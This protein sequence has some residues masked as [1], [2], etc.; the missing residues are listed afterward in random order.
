MVSDKAFDYACLFANK[1]KADLVLLHVV[2]EENIPRDQIEGSPFT[3]PSGHEK[4]VNQKLETLRNDAEQAHGIVARTRIESGQVDEVIARI[5]D[6]EKIDLIVMGTSGAQ[7]ISEIFQATNT[8]SVIEKSRCPV[9][10]IPEDTVYT[11]PEKWIFASGLDNEFEILANE[12]ASLSSS[13]NAKLEVLNVVKKKEERS[14][15]TYTHNFGH[16]NISFTQIQNKDVLEGINDYVEQANPDL[17]VVVEHPHKKWDWL[18]K[19]DKIGRIVESAN[20]PILVLQGE[21]SK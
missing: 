19:E 3:T 6:E 12:V 16:G 21:K 11:V 1:F 8:I 2:V 17:L 5:G 18:Y 4:T 10:V 20:F 9:L 14:P 15:E 13:F 7:S